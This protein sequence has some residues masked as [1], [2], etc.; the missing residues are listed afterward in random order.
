[1]TVFAAGEN[2]I[3]RVPAEMTDEQLEGLRAEVAERVAR[4]RGPGLPRTTAVILDVS[5]VDTLDSYSTRILLTVAKVARL[6]GA[7]SVIVGIDPNVA[8][9]MVQ[10]G[11]SLD[12]VDTALDVDDALAFLEAERARER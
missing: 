5:S 3:V 12:G 11:L 10:L 1:M 6:R 9:A 7:A 4:D 8:F 2:I